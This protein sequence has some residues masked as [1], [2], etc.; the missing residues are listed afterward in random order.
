M[1]G[2]FQLP[3]GLKRLQSGEKSKIINSEIYWNKLNKLRPTEADLAV[4][5]EPFEEYGK[6]FF[7]K[8]AFLDRKQV[9]CRFSMCLKFQVVADLKSLNS[10]FFFFIRE[11]SRGNYA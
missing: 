11:R 6:K 8:F 3:I 1:W 5:L 4:M 2:L 9:R 10:I 7:L